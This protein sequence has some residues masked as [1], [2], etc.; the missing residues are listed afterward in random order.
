MPDQSQFN[1]YI[2]I[3]LIIGIIG[4]IWLINTLWRNWKISKFR[5]W[6]RARATVV[7]VLAVPT[8]GKIAVD[9]RN[10]IATT[11]NSVR[12]V[13]K[14]LYVYEVNGREYR[15]DNV[16]YHGPDSLNAVDTKMLL[17]QIYPNNIITILYNPSNPNDAYIYN[18]TQNNTGI[19]IGVIL[20]LL[21]GFLFYQNYKNKSGNNDMTGNDI[22]TQLSKATHINIPTSKTTTISKTTMPG[23]ATGNNVIEI[24]SFRKGLLY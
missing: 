16:F 17:G 19:I 12:Y 1:I 7:N 8:D 21:S 13:P 4:L 24:S 11:N 2:I 14:I 9:P 15:S 22:L 3:A 6:P 5:S 23:S 20:L 18:G 10:I